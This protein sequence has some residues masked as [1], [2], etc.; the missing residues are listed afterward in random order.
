MRVNARYALQG[1]FKAASAN[2][3]AFARRAVFLQ[4][5]LGQ[6]LRAAHVLLENSVVRGALAN[7]EMGS[8]PLEVTH[9]LAEAKMKNVISV[10]REVFVK[11]DA[12]RP[13]YV[14]REAFQELD[15]ASALHAASIHSQLHQDCQHVNFATQ[16]PEIIL[17]KGLL[18]ANSW[19][20]TLLFFI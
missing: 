16:Q 6:T 19:S 17:W 9:L 18:D 13:C 2:L 11:Q 4:T 3:Y 1:L 14:V 10:H 15:K 8:A 12:S 20:T 7:L 5:I